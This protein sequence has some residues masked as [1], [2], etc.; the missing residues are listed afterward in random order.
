VQFNTDIDNFFGIKRIKNMAIVA[1]TDEGGAV[2]LVQFYN[3]NMKLKEIDHQRL[4][5]LQ[6][7][8]GFH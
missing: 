6:R 7:F 1:T 2:G 4:R 8:M 3:K 5:A